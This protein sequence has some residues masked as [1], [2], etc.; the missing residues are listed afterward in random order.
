LGTRRNFYSNDYQKM[1]IEANYH[2]YQ[3]KD[4][5]CKVHLLS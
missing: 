3:L 5:N 4:T 1:S 2:G